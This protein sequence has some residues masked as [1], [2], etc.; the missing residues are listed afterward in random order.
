MCDSVLGGAQTCEMTLGSERYRSLFRC[1]EQLRVIISTTPPFVDVLYRLG[2]VPL[3]RLGQARAGRDVRSRRRQ[4]TVRRRG[5]QQAALRPPPRDPGVAGES[6]GARPITSTTFCWLAVEKLAPGGRL[7]VIA[8]AGWMN[9]GNADF[10]RERLASELTLGG[11]VAVREL[12][13]VRAGG[14]GARRRPSRARFSSQRRGQPLRVIGCAW[15]RWKTRTA[16][17]GIAQDSWSEGKRATRARAA[18]ATEFMLMASHRGLQG[19]YPMAGQVRLE[20]TCSSRVVT[21]LRRLGRSD[22]G[23]RESCSNCVED[24]PGNPDCR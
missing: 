7:C 24:L 4:P 15:S 3:G 17:Q 9:A 6:T 12:P 8:P 20:R 14:R 18:G 13:V 16:G 11:A 10:L 23:G 21:H 2:A 19:E 1:G 5:E 22:E